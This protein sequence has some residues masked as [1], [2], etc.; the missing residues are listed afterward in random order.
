E[1][2]YVTL[3]DKVHLPLLQITYPTVYGRHEDEAPLDVLAD[4]LG[5]GKTVTVLQKPS[6][7][8]HGGAS[9]GVSP[10]PRTCL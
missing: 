3:E 6:E 1:T 2:R 9:R 5:G 4:I 7:R 10:L 8:R